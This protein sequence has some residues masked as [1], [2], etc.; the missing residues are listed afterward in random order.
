MISSF[1][2]N[3]K[4]NS[5]SLTRIP[6]FQTQDVYFDRDFLQI[7][8]IPINYHRVYHDNPLWKEASDSLLAVI[9][10]AILILLYPFIALGIK[11]SS[12]GPVFFK[13]ERTGYNGRVFICY[14]F[15]TMHIQD[16]GKKKN[17]PDITYDNDSR[18]FAFGK[19]LRKTNLDE[20]PQFI[21]VVKGDMSIVGPR[22]YPVEENAFW[23]ATFPDF[24][25]RF[26]VRPGLTGLS[27]ATGYRGGT[28]NLLHM[29]ERLRRDLTYVKDRSPAMD[30]KIIMLTIHGMLTFNT[31]AH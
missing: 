22:P 16:S 15:R 3:E 10:M 26:A 30:T 25:K 1:L 8:S 14:K 5:S 13:Q 28:L 18:V 31:K 9:G 11:L 23:N 21:N 20:M 24:Y 12:T 19:F 6:F 4:I 17:G 7:Q 2:Q 29:R 27:Q